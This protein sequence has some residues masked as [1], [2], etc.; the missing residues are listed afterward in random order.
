MYKN[1]VK[2]PL[3]TGGNLVVNPQH[4]CGIV[5]ECRMAADSDDYYVTTRIQLDHLVFRD[6]KSSWEIDMRAI[7]AL[8]LLNTGEYP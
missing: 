4:V 2:F 8:T 6:A 7:D 1:F 3:A 5:E